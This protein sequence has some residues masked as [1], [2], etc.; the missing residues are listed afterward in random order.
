MVKKN[1]CGHDCSSTRRKKKMKN[2]TKFW[3]CDEV[4]DWLIEDATLGA[5][6][7]RKKIKEHHKVDIHYKRV[8][9]A[10]AGRPQTERH[11]GCG[12]KKRKSGQ[13]VCPIC[14]EYGHHWHKCKKGNKDDI[15]AFMAVREP[16]KKRRKT[17][18][19][20]ES[21]IVPRGDDAPTAAMYFPPSQNLETTTKKKGKHN[22]TLETTNKKNAKGG[23]RATRKMELAKKDQN[24]LMVPFDSPA[25]GTRSKR[26]YPTSPAMGTRSKRRLS[27]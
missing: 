17:T 3:I 1:P 11:K 27:L 18:K 8:Y 26:A 9:M 19:T 16:P 4:K 5:K 13:H 20:S 24:N 6:A 21:S 12:E 7:L 2:A 10:V 14:K 22:Q 15:V 23:K 25:M